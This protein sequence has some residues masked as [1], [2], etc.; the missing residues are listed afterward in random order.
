MA[1]DDKR[2]GDALARAMDKS[3]ETLAFVEAIPLNEDTP[4]LPDELVP[5]PRTTTNWAKTPIINPFKG[6]IFLLLPPELSEMLTEMMFGMLDEGEL[7]QSLVMDA[8]AELSNVLAGRF[9]DEL[10]EGD[11]VFELGLPERGSVSS[12]AE[13]PLP[14]THMHKLD[15]AVEGYTLTVVLAGVDF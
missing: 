7:D 4:P 5:A 10:L 6:E 1:I 11:A 15:Y 12:D 2:I 9:V 13:V 8:I 3:L 14:D